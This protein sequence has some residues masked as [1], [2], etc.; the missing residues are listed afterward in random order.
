MEEWVAREAK[1]KE[2]VVDEVVEVEVEEMV[3]EK[4]KEEVEEKVEEEKVTGAGQW[5]RAFWGDGA[6][7]AIMDLPWDPAVLAGPHPPNFDHPLLV[8]PESPIWTLRFFMH[9]VHHKIL[10]Q[11]RWV[12]A[13]KGGSTRTN[14][15]GWGGG[16]LQGPDGGN[17]SC[18]GGRGGKRPPLPTRG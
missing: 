18:P 11:G 5:L 6:A 10:G 14:P 4:V 2:E 16:G 8:P 1:V 17:R 12:W 15:C 7:G 3:E 13:D 9:C